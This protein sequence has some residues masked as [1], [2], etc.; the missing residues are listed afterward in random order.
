YP[1]HFS[2]NLVAFAYD[3]GGRYQPATDTWTPIPTTGFYRFGHTAV[4]SGAEMLLLGGSYVTYSGST[5]T[6]KAT[7]PVGERYN[8]SSGTWTALPSAGEPSGGLTF[9]TGTEM[10]V[11]GSPGARYNPGTDSWT[12]LNYSGLS[13][14]AT[15]GATGVWT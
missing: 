5:P 13:S 8:P 14:R 15:D 9:W 1:D 10:L 4:W 2:A 7:S 3:D 12:V 6:I 11:L